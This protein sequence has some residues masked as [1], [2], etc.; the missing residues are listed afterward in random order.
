MG[1]GVLDT[2]RSLP[3][4]LAS[5]ETEY[6]FMIKKL[7]EI[8]IGDT[9]V[10]LTTTH[11]ALICISIFLI[12]F[13]LI[14]NRVLLKADPDA[15]PGPF[16]NFLEII[17][18]M[19]GGMV[20]GLMGTN[21]KRF[22]NYISSI[23]LFI[24]IC[25]LGGLFGLR[26]PTADYGVTLPLALFTFALIHY[27]GI[28]KKKGK[29]FMALFEPI[30]LFFPINLISEVATPLSLSI[31]LFGNVMSGTVLMGLVYAMF[32]LFI[33]IIPLPGIMHIYFDVF[34]GAIQT[35]VFCMLTMVYINDK[36]S[37]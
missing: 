14:A 20:D 15:T 23:F 22:V 19:L 16:Q 18:D 26:A 9:T 3:L 24:L 30:P 4:I 12:V 6:D 35:Y 5:S 11:V 25:N 33:Q 7:M 29:H 1:S 2:A 34:S 21:A 37:D 32:P 27:N 17:T 36:I 8:H 10:Y 28:K 13:A 31:R